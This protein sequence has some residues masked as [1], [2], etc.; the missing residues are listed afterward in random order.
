MSFRLIK[1]LMF[2]LAAFAV[3]SG[4]M[5][6]PVRAIAAQAGMTVIMAGDDCPAMKAHISCVDCKSGPCKMALSDCAKMMTS[7]DTLAGAL[8][9]PAEASMTLAY[10]PVSYRDTPFALQGRAA[11]PALFP[12][13]PA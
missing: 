11:E 3:F 1:R 8:G 13:R 9:Q 2:V 10:L 5:A 6:S 4:A 12:P 7:C